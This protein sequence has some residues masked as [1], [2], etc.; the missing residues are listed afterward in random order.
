MRKV[1]SGHLPGP[2]GYQGAEEG[3]GVVCL[4][5]YL[6]GPRDKMLRCERVKAQHAREKNK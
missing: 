2:S 5:H 1:V 3:K 4:D 6:Q